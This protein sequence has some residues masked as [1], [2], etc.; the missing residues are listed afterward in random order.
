MPHIS[1]MEFSK[2]KLLPQV[3]ELLDQRRCLARVPKDEK[4]VQKIAEIDKMLTGL[5]NQL[6]GRKPKDGLQ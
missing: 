5:S 2:R 4:V 6:L 1:D 3:D